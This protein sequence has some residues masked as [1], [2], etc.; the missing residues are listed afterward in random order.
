MIVR[1]IGTVAIRPEQCNQTARIPHAHVWSQLFMCT[2]RIASLRGQMSLCIW[3]TRCK[4]A[5]DSVQVGCVEMSSVLLSSTY[6]SCSLLSGS[7]A[8]TNAVCLETHAAQSQHCLWVIVR[9]RTSKRGKASHCCDLNAFTLKC[10][11][12]NLHAAYVWTAFELCLRAQ[13]QLDLLQQTS[14]FS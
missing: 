3:G 13:N 11:H 4:I 12:L 1:N 2:W 9:Q 14:L 5:Q 7:W 8:E 10:P 6:R